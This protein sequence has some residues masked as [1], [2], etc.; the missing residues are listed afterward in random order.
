MPF[1]TEKLKKKK[2]SCNKNEMRSGIIDIILSQ[3][4]FLKVIL[5]TLHAT[6]LMTL[7]TLCSSSLS[8]ADT[9]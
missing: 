9:I 3:Y 8:R 2:V 4:G 7:W 1:S 5:T 6:L